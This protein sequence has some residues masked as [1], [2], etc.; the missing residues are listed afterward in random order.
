MT[1]VDKT[2]ME[3]HSD[4]MEF[5][6]DIRFS[7]PNKGM[8]VSTVVITE[9]STKEVLTLEGVSQCHPDDQFVKAAGRLIALRRSTTKLNK[10]IGQ[11]EFRSVLK[12]TIFGSY[13]M[14]DFTP[15]ILINKTVVEAAIDAKYR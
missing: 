11:S 3:N 15:I 8:C 7:Y 6:F 5:H 13:F 1:D 14:R 12:Q 2:Y 4:I 9:V 10:I